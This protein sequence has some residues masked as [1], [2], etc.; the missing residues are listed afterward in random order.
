MR[1]P[2]H[3]NKPLEIERLFCFLFY[4][5]KKR[6]N[7]ETSRQL[8]LAE[9]NKDYFQLTILLLISSSYETA[10]KQSNKKSEQYRRSTSNQRQMVIYYRR[11][12]LFLPSDNLLREI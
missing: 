3:S 7:L 6:L 2:A 4:K 8:W 1:V 9:S 10:S 12:K 5:E 11:R